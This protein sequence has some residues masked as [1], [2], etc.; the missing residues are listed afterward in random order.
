MGLLFL[1]ISTA[2][3]LGGFLFALAMLRSGRRRP[4]ANMAVMGAGFVFQCLFLFLRGELHG[5]CPITS[6][7]EVLVFVSWSIVIMYFVVGKAFRLSLIGLFTAPIV[8]LFQAVAL[9]WLA[10]GPRSPPA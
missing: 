3:F 4:V 5:R 8:F 2:F 7:P 10:A 6:G 1:A 9:A